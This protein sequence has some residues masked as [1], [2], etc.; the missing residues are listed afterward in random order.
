MIKNYV[1]VRRDSAN[2]LPMDAAIIQALQ[3]Y[4]VGFNLMPLPKTSEPKKEPTYV[5]DRTPVWQQPYY[6]PYGHMV[7]EKDMGKAKA[8]KEKGLSTFFLR[9][10]KIVTTLQLTVMVAAC[11]SITI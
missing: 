9:S 4:E 8:R 3:S 2:L 5:P 10:F 1:G 11:V 6:Q 7:K